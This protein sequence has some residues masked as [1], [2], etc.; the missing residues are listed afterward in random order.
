MPIEPRKMESCS[1][2]VRTI[3]KDGGCTWT[4]ANGCH[5]KLI[6]NYSLRQRG[7][8]SHFPSAC[9]QRKLHVEKPVPAANDG[10]C[11][12]LEI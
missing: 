10:A 5:E 2:K 4:H 8:T 12:V 11:D 1:S 7:Q 3:A 9:G 6:N